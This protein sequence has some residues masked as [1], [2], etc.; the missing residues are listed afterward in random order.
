MT[1]YHTDAY[2]VEITFPGDV[3]DQVFEVGVMHVVR[4][5][6]YNDGAVCIIKETEEEQDEIIFTPNQMQKHRMRYKAYR[7]EDPTV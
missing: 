4:I 7:G 1:R 5:F 2:R 6:R 3:A